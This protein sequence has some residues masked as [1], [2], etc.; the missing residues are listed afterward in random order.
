MVD[1]ELTTKHGI[2]KTMLMLKFMTIV[3]GKKGKSDYNRFKSWLVQQLKRG[4]TA[5]EGVALVEGILKYI[6]S[7]PATNERMDAMKYLF[8]AEFLN[9]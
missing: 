5:Q 1:M 2:D 8:G 9:D 4:L 3:E 7:E 6:Q